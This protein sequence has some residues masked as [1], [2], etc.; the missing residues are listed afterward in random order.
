VDQVWAIA[1]LEEFVGSVERLEELGR[2]G[3]LVAG[4][5]TESYKLDND[6]AEADQEVRTLEPVAQII[7]EAVSPGLSAYESAD[8]ADHWNIRFTPA[9]NAA[10]RALGLVRLGAEAKERMRPDAPELV[11]DQL[12]EWVWSAA[13]P[14]WEANSYSAA[15]HHAAQSVNA[16][17][18]K[19]LARYDV[20]ETALCAE[21]FSLEA[22][23]PGRP[24]LRFD[25][26]RTSQTWKA[27]Q[28]GAGA[29][30]RGCFL[31][32]RNPAAHKPSGPLP[33]QLAL[34]ELAAFSR[35]ARWIEECS[36]ETAQ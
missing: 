25:G 13:R 22:P 21:A 16:Q 12:H 32:M 35:L 14:M 3:R 19:K 34:E 29:F 4:D 5:E 10:L 28:E 7:M 6:M 36:V 9:K 1:Q 27:R 17:L 30:G 20:G 2:V 24:R 33:V 11:A 8:Q 18:Q 15:V 26:D 23:K 31:A